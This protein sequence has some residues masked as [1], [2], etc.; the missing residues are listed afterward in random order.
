MGCVRCGGDIPRRAACSLERLEANFGALSFE[1]FPRGLVN[2]HA[3]FSDDKCIGLP[4]VLRPKART[5]FVD[6]RH[7][8]ADGEANLLANSGNAIQVGHSWIASGCMKV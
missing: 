2:G 7:S 3:V 1:D 5:A 6:R 8:V 4:E